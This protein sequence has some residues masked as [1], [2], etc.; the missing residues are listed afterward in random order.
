MAEA[1]MAA[2]RCDGP[3][4]P[5]VQGQKRLHSPPSAPQERMGLQRGCWRRKI[6]VYYFGT[7]D[8]APHAQQPP[9]ATRRKQ[10]IRHVVACLATTFA[11]TPHHDSHL[12]AM[13][14]G[15]ALQHR[16]RQRR[17]AYPVAHACCSSNIAIAPPLVT[18]L[19][20]AALQIAWSG[21]CMHGTD[22]Q[23][24]H[25]GTLGGTTTARSWPPSGHAPAASPDPD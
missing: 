12:V 8:L 14:H 15:P 5:H 2:P 1:G 24:M 23:G 21:L 25:F 17:Y 20:M 6:E 16:C 13:A 18:S 3:R 7:W 22:S 11:L 9:S 19:A 10:C 4:R